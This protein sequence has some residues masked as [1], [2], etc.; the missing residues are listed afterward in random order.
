MNQ[1]T[2]KVTTARRI[3]ATRVVMNPG[4]AGL[5]MVMI[6]KKDVRAIG[7]VGCTVR[8]LDSVVR[9]GYTPFSGL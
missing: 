7:L 6:K 5:R 9:S 1:G 3:V 4:V 8:A 2:E